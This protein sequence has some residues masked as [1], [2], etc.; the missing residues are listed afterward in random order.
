MQS[1]WRQKTYEALQTITL[2]G[3]ILDLG[4]GKQS[5]YHQLIQGDHTIAV[6]NL[7]NGADNDYQFDFEQPF[8]IADKMFD[9]ILC[10]NVLE[11]ISDYQHLL[12]ECHRILQPNG[13]MVIA[14]PF[15]IRYHPSPNDYWRYTEVTLE[16]ILLTAGFRQVEIAPIGTGVFGAAYSMIHN[17]LRFGFVQWPIR[18]I[19]CGL[20]WLLARLAPRSAYTTKYYP[21]GYVV[22]AV[23]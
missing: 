6:A 14:V 18:G 11:H 7:D 13:T 22:R 10:I 16:K 3:T 15:L 23:R 1:L 8:P 4:G 17:V 9:S 12:D 19:A 21:L 5:Y 2:N 20:D